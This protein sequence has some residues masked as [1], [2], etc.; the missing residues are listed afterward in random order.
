MVWNDKI[1]S[2][3]IQEAVKNSMNYIYK[4]D[5][6]EIKELDEEDFN[7]SIIHSGDNTDRIDSDLGNKDNICKKIG[8][9]FFFSDKKIK[10]G[11]FNEFR[12]DDEEFNEISN[13]NNEVV[14]I[15]IEKK[16]K[17]KENFVINNQSIQKDSKINKKT[18]FLKNFGNEEQ[19]NNQIKKFELEN[20]FID[21]L[22]VL[23]IKSSKINKKSKSLSPNLNFKNFI[24]IAS[25]NVIENSK[26]NSKFTKSEK[27]I[28]NQKKKF[29]KKRKKKSLVNFKRAF[30]SNKINDSKLSIFSKDSKLKN[31]KK[32]NFNSFHTQFIGRC[33][34]NSILF[35]KCEKELFKKKKSKNKKI[36]IKE[37]K[38]SI[39]SFSGLH[40]KIISSF[41]N[42]KKNENQ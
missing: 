11:N 41:N 23:V 42:K 18:D 37:R 16:M 27:N 31:Y 5:C 28:K 20:R 2:E 25:K 38:G 24:T 13:K 12:D 35:D 26:M 9:E 21:D 19:S 34:K 7:S 17:N 39:N 8:D 22:G 3:K 10:N 40:D 1:R 33:S 14:K 32:T 4:G 15:K 6:E 29:N 36:L 30:K